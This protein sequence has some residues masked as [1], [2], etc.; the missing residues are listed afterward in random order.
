M[1][2]E[3]TKKEFQS[4][5][6]TPILIMAVFAFILCSRFLSEETLGLNENPY[7]AVVVIQMLTYALPSLFYTRLRGREFGERTRLRLFAPSSSLYVLH[8]SVFLLCGV[9]LISIFMYSAFPDSFSESAVTTYAA[10]AMNGRLFDIVYLVIA[11]ALLPA[12]TEEYLFRGIV[13]AEYEKYGVGVAALMSAVTFAMSHFSVARFPVYLFSGIVLAM[14]MYTTRSVIASAIAH[15]LNNTFVLIGEKFVFRIAD[16]QN[17]SFVLFL[18]IVGAAMIVSA[19]L[20]CYEAQGIYRGYADENVPADYVPK[21]K[22]NAFRR[23]AEAFFTPT[24]LIVVII[25]VVASMT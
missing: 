20:M 10:F 22:T 11:F 3:K 23:I 17:V 25:F 21:K 19:M 15:T 18:I 8:T 14:C 6:F 4:A 7:L 24:F 9:V 16:K 5:A 13:A 1:N 12:L 2:A